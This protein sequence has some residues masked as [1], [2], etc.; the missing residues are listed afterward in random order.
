VSK[1]NWT[2]TSAESLVRKRGT[3]GISGATLGLKSLSL[4]RFQTRESEEVFTTELAPYRDVATARKA[5]ER[6]LKERDESAIKVKRELKGPKKLSNGK[7]RKKKKRGLEKR[8]KLLEQTSKFCQ[9][10]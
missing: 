5:H 7:K 10:R 1:I 9:F 2:R 8:P 6:I 3:I 4:R